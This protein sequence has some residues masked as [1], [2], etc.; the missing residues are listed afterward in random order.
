MTTDEFAA[1]FV[2][3]TMKAD[4]LYVVTEPY[5]GDE[6]PL[7]LV[8]MSGGEDTY[9]A[10]A[11]WMPW[12]SN[13]DRITAALHFVMALKHKYT[14]LFAIPED[15]AVLLQHLGRYGVLRK[16]GTIHK[17]YQGRDAQFWQAK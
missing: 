8:I 4:M 17:Y 12:A 1:Y 10:H 6:R 2:E 3:R 5:N 7:V 15:D 9:E 14:L 13:R 16:V 11:Q